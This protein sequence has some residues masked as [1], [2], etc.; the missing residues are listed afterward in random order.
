MGTSGKVERSFPGCIRVQSC[1]CDVCNLC[2]YTNNNRP[3]YLFVSL[4]GSVGV[5]SRWPSR[6]HKVRGGGLSASPFEA[7]KHT[8]STPLHTCREAK[9]WISSDWNLTKYGRYCIHQMG[10]MTIQYLNWDSKSDL[11]NWKSIVRECLLKQQHFQK[12]SFSTSSTSYLMT[13]QCQCL[14]RDS[15]VWT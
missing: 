1:S 15:E 3:Y 14:N 5:D 6:L 10:M 8:N 9:R 7:E 13:I 2:M 4:W 11:E 12:P